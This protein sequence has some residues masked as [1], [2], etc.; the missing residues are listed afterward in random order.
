MCEVLA[1]FVPLCR[2]SLLHRYTSRTVNYTTKYEDGD[3]QIKDSMGRR[4]LGHHHFDPT[5]GGVA[6]NGF[7]LLSTRGVPLGLLS[8]HTFS[9][10]ADMEAR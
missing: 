10:A 2:L 3:A 9:S 4:Q 5:T 8:V 6:E 1:C 7:C